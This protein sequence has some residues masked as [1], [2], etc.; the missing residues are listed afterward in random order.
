[1]RGTVP[2]GTHARIEAMK[3]ILCSE[4]QK[5]P[6]WRSL[7]AERNVSA[8]RDVRLLTLSNLFRSEAREDRCATPLKLAHLLA[9]RQEE[10]PVYRDM[11]PYPAFV[12]EILSFA[13]SLALYGIHPEELPEST[14][15][16]KELQNILRLALTLP[17][18]ETECA[19][20][21]ND[22]LTELSSLEDLEIRIRFEADPFRFRFLSEL[23][24]QNPK[25][26]LRKE[27]RTPSVIEFRNARS[28]RQ[29]AEACAQEIV[30]RGIPCAVVLADYGNTVMVTEQV[31]SRYEIPYST[32]SSPCTPS[33]PGIFTVLA[34]LALYK[35]SE[36]L[37]EA[38]R[39]DA[40]PLPC[41]EPLLSWL[42]HTLTD[43]S[44]PLLSGA[45]SDALLMQ[46]KKQAGVMDRM[47]S[48]Y[49]GSIEPWL[50]ALLSVSAPGEALSAAYEVMKENPLVHVPS[51][52]EAG[53]SILNHL[54]ETL[55]LIQSEQ[56][57][58]FVLRE[59]DGIRIRTSRTASSFCT[60]TDLFHPCEPAETL[61]VLGCSSRSFPGAPVM[62]GLFDESYVS[63][64]AS[65][66]SLEERHTLFKEQ[67]SWLEESSD[68]LIYSYASGDYQG[69]A[70]E[71]S[72]ELTSRFSSP[73]P[74]VIDSLRPSVPSVHKLEP[75]TAA[76]L[77]TKEDGRI[78]SSISR[79][80]RFFCCPYSWF[81]QS[82]LKIRRPMTAAMDAATA[83]NLQHAFMEHAAETAGKQYCSL[84][85]EDIREF[86]SPSFVS[87]C[88]MYPKETTMITL[89]EER[90]IDGLE[91]SLRILSKIEAAG[92][93]WNPVAAES[94]FDQTITDGVQLNGII[95][96]I[97]ESPASLR[98]LDYK[99]SS[100]SLS[101]KKIL[102]GLQLQLLSYLIIAVQ[103]RGLHPAGVYYFSLK[104]D[105]TPLKAGTFK[106][107][108]KTELFRDFSDPSLYESAEQSAR[109]VNGWAIDDPLIDPSD[110]RLLFNPGTGF[111]D[112]DSIESL[113]KELYRIFYEDAVSG[114]TDVDP[115]E[116]ACMFCDYRAVCRFHGEERTPE[117]VISEEIS[118]KAGK[119]ED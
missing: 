31:F 42:E 72:F 18:S 98:I 90:M 96:R 67:L 13:R 104:P 114:K 46:E 15:G 88:A 45:I 52:M 9:E 51:E 95:D 69:R 70:I 62:K 100:K 20:R 61:Y 68:R 11:F 1:M 60:I 50:S 94:R 41:R 79:I 103:E 73:V 86:L 71:P 53:L 99:S 118:L 84:T 24:E 56:D 27:V 63:N 89:W 109:R 93:V 80:E 115:V 113:L 12:G 111:H 78:H 17:L 16:Q 116:G 119:E 40:F 26:V 5:D 35:D 81:L 22:V 23:I 101:E 91:R 75:D 47:A 30:R 36:H 58:V 3:T 4:E 39:H 112:Y 105:N 87:L 102:A 7:L 97:D 110:Y 49:F 55:P 83:G 107:T 82:G 106:K 77:Y 76:S 29:E 66:P 33:L 34:R 21:R 6:I 10:F 38:L 44:A 108:N 8:I 25:A 85:K 19:A 117:P 64:V 92:P 43:L 32:L 57:A 54:N 59:I 74:W 48:E 14:A 65:F 28:V 2:S 37:L